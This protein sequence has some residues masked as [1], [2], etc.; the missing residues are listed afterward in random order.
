MKTDHKRIEINVYINEQDTF[1]GR[2][3][4]RL[5]LEKLYDINVTGAT[6]IAALA[7]YGGNFEIKRMGFWPWQKN[8]SLV[9]RI[10]ERE[11][12]KDKILAMLEPMISGG[13]IT[14]Q[15]VDCIRYTPRVIT[16][17]DHRIAQESVGDLPSS[18]LQR[19]TK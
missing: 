5:I 1:Q 18:L 19:L 6:V 17:E 3:L 15:T 16:E 11:Q 13:I 12:L 9:I 10:I 7:S 8:R 2:K 14:I 4:Y